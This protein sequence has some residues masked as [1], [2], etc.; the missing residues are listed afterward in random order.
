MGDWPIPGEFEII[1][2]YFAP[3]AVSTGALGLLDDAALVTP[4]PG[5]ELVL[6]VD[7][8]IAGVHFL[9]DDPADLV[10]QKLLRVNLSDL[11]AM[12]ATPIGYLLTTAWP[13][14]C[15]EKWIAGFVAGLARD[16]ATFDVHLYGGDTVST[17]G[18]LALTLTAFGSVPAGQAVRRQ[19]ACVGDRVHVTGSIGDGALGLKAARGELAGVDQTDKAYLLARYRLPE[20]RTAIGAALIG[21]ATAMIDISDGLAADA[22][23]IAEVSGVGLVLQQEKV[24]LSPAAE[25]RISADPSLQPL[26]LSGGD[27][28]ELLFTAPPEAGERIA[29]L[30]LATGIPIAEIGEVVAGELVRIVDV[31]GTDLVL[32]SRGW[33]HF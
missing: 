19:G 2:R 16:Q 8:M 26:V 17:S 23:H 33:Q 15:T 11:A 13:R 25:R 27:D 24:P 18:P 9:E 6:T 14:S 29:A 12:G 22:G 20:P 32:P 7:A 30:A 4:P 21:I 10:G 31:A 28:Y 3:L 5:C 1:R